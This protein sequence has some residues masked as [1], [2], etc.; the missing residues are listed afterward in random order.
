RVRYLEAWGLVRPQVRTNADRFY[1]FPNVLVFR[2]AHQQ[3]AQGR[4]LR[5]VVQRLRAE[6]AGQP[7]LDFA[8]QVTLVRVIP[9]RRRRPERPE[10]VEEWFERGCALDE[11]PETLA[12]ARAAYERALEL[13]PNYVPALINLGNLNYSQDR[14]AEV[15]ACFERALR[16]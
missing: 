9:F 8:H 13:D 11:D 6:Q 12:E 3:L 1:D 5:S 10:S 2:H 4:P 16:L 14:P 15:Q 7:V